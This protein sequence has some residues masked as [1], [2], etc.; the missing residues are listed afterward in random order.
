MPTGIA[1]SREVAEKVNRE[2]KVNKSEYAN[3]NIDR[4]PLSSSAMSRETGMNVFSNCCPELSLMKIT[5]FT[6]RGFVLKFKPYR[7][8]AF[9]NCDNLFQTHFFSMRGERCV[10]NAIL[11]YF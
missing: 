6:G 2:Q 7:K 4:E 3:V 5:T 1:P 8:K 9:R 11:A 10:A